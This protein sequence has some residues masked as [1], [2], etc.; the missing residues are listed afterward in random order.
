M[1]QSEPAQVLAEDDEDVDD[2]M[3]MTT[4]ATMTGAMTVMATVAVEGHSVPA[5][6]PPLPSGLRVQR[7]TEGAFA[8]FSRH[9]RGR[10]WLES[11]TGQCE[12]RGA[13]QGARAADE[14]SHVS[15]EHRATLVPRWPP[16]W[17]P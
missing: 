12:G 15:P 3:M 13:A 8:P 9:S 1:A 16:C 14:G 4:W 17:A 7:G 6:C 2:V 5:T 10:A 11:S